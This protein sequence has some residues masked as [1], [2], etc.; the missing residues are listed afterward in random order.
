MQLASLLEV[1]F[2]WVLIS[3]PGYP[4]SSATWVWKMIGD[5]GA[6]MMSSAWPWTNWASQIFPE[7]SFLARSMSP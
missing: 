4:H 3:L 7:I 5:S 1:T 2:T 6:S